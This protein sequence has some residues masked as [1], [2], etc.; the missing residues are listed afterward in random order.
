MIKRSHKKELVLRIMGFEPITNRLK[1]Y[2]SAI[3]LYS[4]TY[5][6]LKNTGTL[7]FAA[8]CTLDTATVKTRNVLYK[9]LRVL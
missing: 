1:A 7:Y 2:C 9:D 8:V 3:E 4:L 6:I 5:N